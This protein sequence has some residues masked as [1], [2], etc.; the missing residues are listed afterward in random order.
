MRVDYRP[1]SRL[2]MDQH[3]VRELLGKPLEY[4]G[5]VKLPGGLSMQG[6]WDAYR[7]QEQAHS[8]ARIGFTYT[9]SRH[10]R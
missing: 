9:A 8:N 6:G 2:G 7:L 1:R 4:R 3:G 5:P 10:E